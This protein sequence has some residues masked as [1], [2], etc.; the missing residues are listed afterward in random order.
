M[1]NDTAVSDLTFF[2]KHLRAGM[3]RETPLILLAC[4]IVFSG[5]AKP[6][7]VMPPMTELPPSAAPS[8]EQPARPSA[9]PARP[10]GPATAA[11]TLRPITEREISRLVEVDPDLTYGTAIEILAR[12]NIKA[13]YYIPN[14]L[15]DGTPL[16]VPNDFRAFKN[17]T[18][19][20]RTIP[21]VSGMPKFILIVK[22]I[23]FLGW[24]EKGRL[25]G[26]TQVCIGKKDGWTD[27]GFYRVLEKDADHFSRSYLNDYGQPTPMP[28]ALRIYGTVWIHTGDVVGGYCSHG[29]INLPL[30]QSIK[31]FNWADTRTRVLIVPSLN[32]LTPTLAGL[33]RQLAETMADD[34]RGTLDPRVP[35]PGNK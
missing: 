32:D 34:P 4:L 18:P 30:T 8:R 31:L 2:E 1:M 12:L 17:W 27:E 19:L 5:C 11:W 25:K 24:Y 23:P 29:C 10:R 15:Q 21:E 7:V 3:G 14:Y 26:D 13:R 22:D 20:P 6:H 28:N 33:S 16:R 35:V 9:K